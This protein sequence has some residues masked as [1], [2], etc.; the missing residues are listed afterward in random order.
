LKL[1][2]DLLYEGGIA[3]MLERISDTAE[4]GAYVGGPAVIGDE[5]RAGM[6]ALLDRIQDGSFAG[7][8]IAESSSGKKRLHAFREAE[9]EA[10]IEKVGNELRSHMPFLKG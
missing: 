10:D 2:V 1:I 6:K 3:H 7:E 8:W 9:K 4:W 5:S